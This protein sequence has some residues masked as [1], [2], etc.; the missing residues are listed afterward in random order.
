MYDSYVG[1]SLRRLKLAVFAALIFVQQAGAPPRRPDYVT[2]A[3]ELL[4]DNAF[5]YSL[6]NDSK[7]LKFIEL[8]NS[9]V[10]MEPARTQIADLAVAALDPA[11]V[12]R[13]HQEALRHPR[14]LLILEAIAQ[15]KSQSSPFTS[16]QKELL[17]T[18]LVPFLGAHNE[19]RVAATQMRAALSL[20]DTVVSH[21]NVEKK[22]KQRLDDEE[23][24]KLLPKVLESLNSK[25]KHDVAVAARISGT[26]FITT[27]WNLFQSQLSDADRATYGHALARLGPS[28]EAVRELDWTMRVLSRNFEHN[29]DV[30]TRV[31]IYTQVLSDPLNSTFTGLSSISGTAYEDALRSLRT[32]VLLARDFT[33]VTPSLLDSVSDALDHRSILMQPGY[34]NQPR[35]DLERV[36]ASMV[37]ARPDLMQ[38]KYVNS[39]L[40]SLDIGRG[41]EHREVEVYKLLQAL[42]QDSR[43]HAIVEEK[44]AS[45]KASQERHVHELG[46]DAEH[47]KNG[48]V[49][50][51]PRY[52]R[53]D[54][55]KSCAKAMSK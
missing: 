2:Q 52:R 7:I 51:S 19:D 36:L 1:T 24:K 6:E 37:L 42:S 44:I 12:G 4:N 55:L 15:K 43:Y 25:A 10:I 8:L 28:D 45:W 18:R 33:W 35:H 54:S 21:D 48:T 17:R 49:E 47:L 3:R 31:A 40:N 50:S 13:P 32:D 20:L 16:I 23:K 30:E 53:S 29:F 11:F 26:R 27:N 38:P 22:E 34:N 46:E 14:A 9:D 5:I 41:D 39:F